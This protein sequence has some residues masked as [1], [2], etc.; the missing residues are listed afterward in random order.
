MFIDTRDDNA[1]ALAIKDNDVSALETLISRHRRGLFCKAYHRLESIEDAE[2]VVMMLFEQ[3]W[4]N[5][6]KRWDPLG[7]ATFKHYI[8]M[9]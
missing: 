9:I 7:S 4:H 8:I 1:L 3:V 5:A 2:D 6:A